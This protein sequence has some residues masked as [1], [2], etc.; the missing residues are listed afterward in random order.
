[1]KAYEI[2]EFDVLHVQRKAALKTAKLLKVE[3]CELMDY[4]ELQNIIKEKDAELYKMLMDF[5]AAYW[6]YY[7]YCANAIN[8]NAN[9]N[10]IDAKEVEVLKDHIKQKDEFRATLIIEIKKRKKQN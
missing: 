8:G 5:S 6:N 10:K 2:K 4:L 9:G 7:Y 1:M 3:Y